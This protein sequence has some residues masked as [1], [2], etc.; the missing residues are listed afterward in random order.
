MIQLA[1]IL[2]WAYTLGSIPTGF[3]LVRLLKNKDLRKIGSGSTGARNAGRVL[4]RKGF[5]LTLAGDT[6]KGT[7]AVG[8]PLWLNSSLEGVWV[9]LAASTAGHV[10]P[11][12]L[13]FSGGRGVAV[14][15]G[16]LAVAA[17]LPLGVLAVVTGIVALITRRFQIS[18]LVGFL[19]LPFAALALQRPGGEIIAL[20]TLTAIVLYA[21]RAL[22][23]Q[24][25]A[26]TPAPPKK[27]SAAHE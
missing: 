11:V 25:L 9:A 6:A 27:E 26:R 16:A 21:H 17:P 23:T 18:G 1:G 2:F 12:W 15:L 14:S 10:W 13:R 19:S 20:T 5:W 22:I 3:L 4:G 8:L 7:L 24:T